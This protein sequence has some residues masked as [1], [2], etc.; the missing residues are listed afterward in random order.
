MTWPS[1]SAHEFCEKKIGP[2]DAATLEYRRK[3]LKTIALDCARCGDTVELIYSACRYKNDE[4][5]LTVSDTDLKT[6]AHSTFNAWWSLPQNKVQGDKYDFLLGSL[7]GDPKAGIFPLGDVHAIVGS[8]GAGKST[9]AYD[10][11]L[12]QRNGAPV[13]NRPTFERDFLVVLRDR[14]SNS[15][16]R[17]LDRMGI[18][19]DELPHRILTPEQATQHP[20]QVLADLW[21]QRQG[22]QVILI[23]GLDL[24]AAGDIKNMSAITSLLTPL[25]DFTKQKHVALLA[26]LGSP[27]LKKGEEYHVTR[28][29]IIGSTAWARMMDDL[30]HVSEEEE[31][32][33][34]HMVMLSRNDKRQ[35]WESRFVDGTLE[36][37]EPTIEVKIDGVPAGPSR[38]ELARQMAK[39]GKNQTEIARE[40]RADRKSVRAWING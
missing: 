13:A 1:I 5:G 28:D 27:K 25:Q 36:T 2:P 10:M 23:E 32:G 15:F 38:A 40:L 37:I 16:E 39:A 21:T 24:W 17:T 34:R 14:S 26:T 6:L 9:W 11:L 19:A 33:I 3:L 31:T 35:T 18:T 12:N 8:S 4:L 30:L 29:L 22:V 7:N 20:A